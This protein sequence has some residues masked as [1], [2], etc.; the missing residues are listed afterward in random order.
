MDRQELMTDFICRDCL[1]PYPEAGLPHEC[2]NCGGIFTLRDLTFTEHTSVSGKSSGIWR[3]T[4]SIGLPA[5]YPVSYLGEGET[6][7]VPV[8]IRGRDF[9]GKM[10]NLNPSGSFKD[11]ATAVLTSVLRGRNQ[12]NVVEDSS[13]NAGGSLALYGAA[14]GIHCR[15]YIPNG[16]SG[17][18][19]RQIEVCGAEVI[20]VEGPRENAHKAALEAVQRE[21]LPYASH[22]AQPFG[23]AGIATIAFEI[24]ESLGEMP[25]MVFCPIGHGSL[26]TGMLM[27]F[28]ALVRAGKAAKRPRLIG[29]QPE[30]CAPVVSAWQKKP[31]SGT[32]GSSLAEGTMVEN[33][34][35][36]V[37]ILG[38]LDHDRDQV[39]AVTE[40]EIADAHRLLIQAGLYVEPTSAMVLAASNKVEETPGK[41]VLILSGSGLK[42]NT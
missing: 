9:F 11:R 17:P 19:R 20:Q 38:Y 3:F 39:V 30:V 31:F 42:S 28:D 6:P 40:S 10:E 33:P 8:K 32:L 21:G 1:Q 16:T 22:A 5:S 36:L 14:F 27:G 18:K 24:F 37:E 35:R 34:A 2:P 25:G 41:S 12:L 23:M 26:F 13:G 7:L 29:V 15:I 4:E